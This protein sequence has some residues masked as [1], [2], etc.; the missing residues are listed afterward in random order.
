MSAQ[1]T[2]VCNAPVRK[3]S[4]EG[5]E[6]TAEEL[7]RLNDLRASQYALMARLFRVEVDQEL[8]DELRATRFPAKTGDAETDEGYRLLVSYLG[9][10]WVDPIKDLAVDYAHVFIGNGT[11]A[12]GAAYPFESVYTSEK[13]LLMQD[14]RDEV[15]AIYRSAGLDKQDSWKEG[16]DHVALELEFEQ[17]LANRTVEALRRGD[18]DEAAALLT[19]QQNFL[20]DHLLSWVPM[21]TADMKR[22]A[23]TDLYQGLAYLTDGFLNTD[24]AFLDDVLTDEE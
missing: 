5:P 17:I 1:E 22:F 24:K 10:A 20:E 7:A 14:A 3:P 9:G 18:E 12:Y 2:P 11:D 23:K 21:M 4:E 8:L 16:E 6:L 13:R 15:L 19:T